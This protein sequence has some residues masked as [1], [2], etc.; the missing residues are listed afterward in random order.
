[1]EYL[2]ARRMTVAKDLLRGHDCELVEMAER[3]GY[4]SVSTFSTAFGLRVGAV[5][6][7]LRARIR[8]CQRERE[9]LLW[10]SDV[11]GNFKLSEVESA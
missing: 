3:V 10:A 11:A 1:M 2:L 5:S 7:S 4:S 9:Y 6:G 8:A